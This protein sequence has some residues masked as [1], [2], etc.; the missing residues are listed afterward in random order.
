MT[1]EVLPPLDLLG[2]DGVSRAVA[3]RLYTAMVALFTGKYDSSRSDGRLTVV[4]LALQAGVGR[5]TA[6]RAGQ[7]LKEFGRIAALIESGAIKA[8]DPGVRVTQLKREIQV[9]RR[10]H[11]EREETPCATSAVP[12]A[13][14]RSARRESRW[15]DFR[16]VNRCQDAEG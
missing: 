3:E 14:V 2:E 10:A 7:I 5:A 12:R 16:S 11:R 13:G 8:A 15:R 9:L 1:G 6:N 4:N